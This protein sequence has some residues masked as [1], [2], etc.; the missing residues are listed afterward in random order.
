M[1]G[2][3]AAQ[4]FFVIGLLWTLL[5]LYCL[6]QYR[7]RRLMLIP[8]TAF[9][10]GALL[11]IVVH[12]VS[13]V[14]VAFHRFPDWLIKSNVV[15]SEASYWIL[16]LVILWLLLARSTEGKRAGEPP[17]PGV[18]A[19][20]GRWR[21]GWRYWALWGCVPVIVAIVTALSVA[22]VEEG[23]GRARK[24]FGPDAYWRQQLEEAKR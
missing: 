17:A 15:F 2:L 9:E 16:G 19:D 5:V 6:A 13:L 11:F 21:V 14:G 10:K 1:Y 22:V 12:L 20:D 24:R 23:H 4:W 7:R 8:D 18:P 3:S